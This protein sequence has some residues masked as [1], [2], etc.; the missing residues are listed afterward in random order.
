[1]QR[2]CYDIK[3][4]RDYIL[5][6][7]RRTPIVFG[8]DEKMLMEAESLDEVIDY[9]RKSW[10][11][12]C[13]YHIIHNLVGYYDIDWEEY[14]IFFNRDVKIEDRWD[15]GDVYCV[16][17]GNGN[18]RVSCWD[19]INITCHIEGGCR[20]N[21]HGDGGDVQVMHNCKVVLLGDFNVTSLGEPDITCYDGSGWV[22]MVF[23]GKLEVRGEGN[24][25]IFAHEE[26][27]VRCYGSGKIF[28]FDYSMIYANGECEVD[29]S[30]HSTCR[31][32][33]NVHVILSDCGRCFFNEEDNVTIMFKD[34]ERNYAIAYA[35][36]D[37]LGI[38]GV[39]MKES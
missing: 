35:I 33:D 37:D 4:L 30:Q 9:I 29:C 10:L 28:G 24:R 14:G 5:S 13:K 6:Q 23:G 21:I 15:I 18:Y 12:C 11:F 7:C 1:M 22:N 19:G 2:N 25:E 3:K 36:G 20:V 34:E 26:S 16:F 8:E 39:Y 27:V 17:F 31:A 32:K 38:S